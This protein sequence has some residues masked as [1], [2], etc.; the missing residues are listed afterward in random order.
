MSSVSVLKPYDQIFDSQKHFRALLQ[1]TARPGTVGQLDDVALDVSAPLSHAT[2][3]LV[4]ALFSGDTTFYLSPADDRVAS[5]VRRET[6]ASLVSADDADFLLYT[7]SAKLESMEQARC[8]TLLYPDLGATL[9]VQVEA[10]SLAPLSGGYRL[11]LAGPGI[12]TESVVYV[13]GVS[14]RLF[15]FLEECNSEF[16][17]GADVFLT[18]DSLSAGPCVL[19]LPRTVRIR[20]E[21]V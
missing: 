2:S 10:I 12:E 15:S 11:T 19:A 14:E 20:W 7:D 21:R 9:V 5:F 3:L 13:L 4:L 17:L 16:P 6:Q 1:C 18:C 8:G